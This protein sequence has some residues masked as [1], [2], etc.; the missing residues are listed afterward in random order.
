MREEVVKRCEVILDKKG[1]SIKICLNVCCFFYKFVN[2]IVDL[3]VV[4]EC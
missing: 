4:G 1:E 3:I 2:I